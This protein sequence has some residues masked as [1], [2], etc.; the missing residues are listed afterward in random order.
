MA[1]SL[2]CMV[3]RTS[4][5]T[6]KKITLGHWENNLELLNG[7]HVKWIHKSWINC[8]RLQVIFLVSGGQT[9]QNLIVLDAVVLKNKAVQK[10]ITHKGNQSWCRKREGG[11]SFET[12]K[13]YKYI[14]I[15]YESVNGQHAFWRAR[16]KKITKN[17]FVISLLFLMCVRLDENCVCVYVCVCA[18]AWQARRK[19]K[20]SAALYICY[21]K[22]CKC[23]PVSFLS[24]PTLA[25]SGLSCAPLCINLDQMSSLCRQ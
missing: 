2:V 20:K 8:K 23:A 5:N 19:K 22:M 12:N 16:E 7:L 18:S 24:D 4:E 25:F 13:I 15:F 10:E 9:R 14:H 17:L 21:D 1:S 11:E 3:H 6:K